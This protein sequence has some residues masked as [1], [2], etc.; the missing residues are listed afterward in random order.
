MRTLKLMFSVFGRPV[1]YLRQGEVQKR[2]STAGFEKVLF[3]RIILDGKC[4][5]KCSPKVY[6]NLLGFRMGWT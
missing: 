2:K 6:L 1:Q 5:V 4:E 3:L